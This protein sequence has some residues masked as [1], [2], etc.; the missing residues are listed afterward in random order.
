MLFI[1]PEAFFIG[2]EGDRTDHHVSAKILH[3]EFEGQAYNVF[4]EGDGGKEMKMSLVNQGQSREAADGNTITLTYEPDQALVLPK[5][6]MAS[7]Q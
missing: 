7:E 2:A 4:L 5:G 1:R 3:E 6:Q